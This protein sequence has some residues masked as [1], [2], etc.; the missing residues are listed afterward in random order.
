[1]F[2]N[3]YLLDRI[4]IIS[5]DIELDPEGSNIV[6]YAGRD[7]RRLPSH[8]RITDMEIDQMNRMLDEDYDRY[9]RP[10]D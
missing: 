10:W 8:R 2:T 4:G 1:M 9:G 7:P 6:A 3:L 5:E